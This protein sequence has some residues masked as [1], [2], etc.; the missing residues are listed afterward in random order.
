M[1]V[2]AMNM[3]MNGDNNNNNNN[4]SKNNHINSSN[5]IGKT[6]EREGKQEKQQQQRQQK[7]VAMKFAEPQILIRCSTSR[8]ILNFFILFHFIFFVVV[9]CIRSYVSVLSLFSFG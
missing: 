5:G 8:T 7:T 3:S 1:E 2:G 4:Y 6:A 9:D